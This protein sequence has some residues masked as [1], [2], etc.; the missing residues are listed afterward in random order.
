[1]LWRGDAGLKDGCDVGTPLYGG[2]FDAG[3]HVKF[4]FPMAWTVTVLGWG[5]ID[6]SAQYKAAGEWSNGLDMLRW[7]LEFFIRAHPEKYVF[8]GQVGDGYADHGFWGRPEDMTMSRPS[9]AIT[10]SSPGSDLAGETAAALAAGS[11]VFKD[12]DPEF[13]AL[14]L[15][16]AKELYEFADQYQGK[17]TDAIPAAD[18]YNSW[19]GYQDE[20]VWGGAWLFRATKD[21]F[22]LQKANQYYSNHV[23]EM[24]SWD[25][26]TPGSQVL[27]AQITGE[28]SYKDDAVKYYQWLQNT[29]QKTPK[30][31]LWLSQWGSNR[32]AANSAF[33]LMQA[34]KIDR[35]PAGDQDSYFKFGAD[36]INYML[37]DGGRSYMVGFGNNPPQKPHHRSSSCPAVP[38]GC[39][40]GQNN[41]GANPFVLYGALVGGP[42]ANDNYVDDRN[43]YVANEVACDYNAAFQSAVAAMMV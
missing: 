3:D 39:E 21:P 6:Y 9:F 17:Y 42:D 7:T 37:G 12:E 26:K 28:G 19:S 15:H 10:K 11:M 32:Y 24:F 33:L 8:Y 4:G 29:A 25:D 22:Y 14:C 5:M 36:Q 41:G 38:A 30:G 40:N 34:K 20:L 43:D 23:A 13:A 18:F 31:L 27:L 2:W 1:M 16:H 35:I